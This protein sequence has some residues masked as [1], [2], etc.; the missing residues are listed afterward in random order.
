MIEWI[1]A[2]SLRARGWVLAVSIGLVVVASVAAFHS[3]L[4][5]LPE[6]SD[7]QVIVKVNFPGQPPQLVEDQVTYP[8]TTALMGVAGTTTVRAISMFGEAFVYVVLTD[9]ADV[10][11][12]R[13]RVLE[14]ITSLS[15]QL[16]QGATV[17]LGPD[18]SG[19]GWVYQYAL[20]A[21]D[22]A[23]AI[24]RLRALQQFFVKPE[25]QSV[26]GVAEV[27]TFGGSARQLQIEVD[28]RRLAALGVTLEEVASGVR[29]ANTASGGSAL[30]LGGQRFLLSA[31]AR[32]HSPE[33]LSDIPVA[34]AANGTIVRLDQVAH[35]SFGPAP[36]ES[37]GDLNGA[38]DTAGGVVV[39]RQGENARDTIAGLQD[40]LVHLRAGLP[41]GVEL[42]TTYDRSVLIDAAVGSLAGRLVEEALMVALVCGVFL[43]RVRSSLVILV[44]LPIGLL[45]ALALLRWQGVTANIMSLGG[46]AIAVG[47]MTDAAIVMVETLHRKLEDPANRA[48]SHHTLVLASAR[49]VGPALCSSLLVIT[50]SFLPVFSLDGQEGKLFAPLALT[51]TYAM[52]TAAALSITLV[53]VLMTVFIRGPVRPEARNPVNLLFARGYRPLLQGVLQHPVRAA[54]AAALVLVSAAMPLLHLGSEFMPPLDEGDLL[55]MPA[56]LPNVSLDEAARIL[57]LTDRL[58]AALPQVASVHGKAGRSDSTTDPAP[59]SMLETTI[60]LKPRS[61]WPAPLSTVELVRAF[62]EKVRLAGL[63]NSWGFPIRTRIDMLASG[64]KAPLALRICGPDL[65]RIQALSERAEHVLRSVPGIRSAFAERPGEGRFIDVRLNRRSASLFGVSATDVTQLIGGALGGVPAGSVS[66]GRERYPIVIRY[67][68]DERDSLPAIRALRVRGSTGNS[69]D[70]ARIATVRVTDGPT[71]LRSENAQPVGYVLLDLDDADVGGVLERAQAALAHAGIREPRYTLDWVGQYLRLQAASLRLVVMA[72]A[73]LL[74]VLV[75]LYAHFRNW[76]R[77][78]VVIASLPFA[79]GGG[80]WLMWLLGYRWSFAAAVGFLALAGVAAEFCVVMIL[81]LDQSLREHCASGQP[82]SAR[83]IHAA[84]IQGAL[85][86]LRPKTM[87]VTVILGGLAPLMLVDGAGVDVMRRIAAPLVGGMI[88]APLF[89]LLVVPTLYVLVLT[90][91]GSSSSAARLRIQHGFTSGRLS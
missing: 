31:D 29:S 36:N 33:D 86:R 59:L 13:E 57:R 82:L 74:C 9:H 16:P 81:Y 63:T 10:N 26:P 45:V 64:V 91:R 40:R 56:T 52:A 89:S 61:Q 39:M 28:P 11:I 15:A 70:L 76:S 65:A 55:Y 66:V 25:L 87:T 44:S 58:I 6:L 35:V 30:D 54:V 37:A 23:V 49:E 8:L 12:A 18:A 80:L 1:I 72:V 62:D 2:A 14:R 68:R 47:A 41:S 50:V 67:P 51:K 78:G 69:V 19:T 7:T 4:D 38:G 46:L 43:S 27:A 17:E 3:K 88:T 42:V 32:V 48:S 90:G 22:N 21:K 34:R 24:D 84:V 71:E 79:A 75:I 5:A 53:P 83:S 77:V 73:T 60:R 85:L 20:V